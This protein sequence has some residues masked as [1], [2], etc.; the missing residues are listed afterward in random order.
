[1]KIINIAKSF[2]VGSIFVAFLFSCSSDN[3]AMNSGYEVDNML[4]TP[5]TVEVKD[6]N[7]IVVR[8]KAAGPLYYKIDNGT[9]FTIDG[10]T[11]YTIPVKQGQ[12][13]QFFGDN[14]TYTYNGEHD[15]YPSY[16]RFNGYVYGNIMSLISKD[17]F[18]SITTMTKD[19]EYAFFS[20]FLNSRIDN[21]PTKKL[22]LPATTLARYCYG[23]M[24]ENCQGLV[25]APA[26][27]ATTL[28][29]YCYASMFYGCR[30]LV[31]ASE[32][33]A[34]TLSKCCYLRMFEN[35]SSLAKS[36]VLLAKKLTDYCYSN[37]FRKCSN[38]KEVTC[39]ATD[40]N[41][42]NSTYRWLEDTSDNGTFIKAKGVDS[43]RI[44]WDGIPEGWIIKE[45]E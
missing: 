37:M 11:Q 34:T 10:D 43:W 22:K 41:S 45:V 39:L 5:L 32:L 21:H 4:S 8:N 1:M 7:G 44:G 25:E 14:P 13:V 9:I 31:V 29:D 36:P 23:Y 20:L 17:N 33:P 19:N 16:I 27:P 18:N 15:K 26:L 12:K 2:I 6:N 35:C 42:S 38:L 28:A 24:F 30:D 3:E 40:L